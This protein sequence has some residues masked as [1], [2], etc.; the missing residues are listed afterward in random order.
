MF[1]FELR[2]G[3]WIILRLAN[4]GVTAA[5]REPFFGSCETFSRQG[6]KAQSFSE[7]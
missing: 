2:G 3:G 5:L 7:S 1:G 6:A 4:P